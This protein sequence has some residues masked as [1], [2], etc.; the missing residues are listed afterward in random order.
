[1][2]ERRPFPLVPKRRPSGLPF[3]EHTGRRRGQ[4]SDAIG[5]RVRKGWIPS[6]ATVISILTWVATATAR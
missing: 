2:V 5:S 3:G 1:M 6:Q 4:G